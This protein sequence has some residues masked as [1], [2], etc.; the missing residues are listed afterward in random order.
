MKKVILLSGLPGSG[1]STYAKKLMKENPH[2]YKRVNK[3]DL[4]SLLDDGKYS[5]GNEKFVLQLRDTIILQALEN[6]KHVIVDDTN[7]NPIH[8]ENIRKLVKG[9]ARVIIENFNVDLKECIERDSKRD[10]P[11]GEK[12]IMDMY[13][14]WIK[15][16]ELTEKYFSDVNKPQAVIF[17]IDGTLAIKDKDRGYYEWSKVGK[18]LVNLRVYDILRLYKKAGYKII[19]FTGKLY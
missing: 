18:D 11:V 12:V 9:K 3:D 5:K 1:K 2:S 14:R 6:G 13:D 8:E 19:I 10:N 4:R 17:D 15:P 7:L 16:K